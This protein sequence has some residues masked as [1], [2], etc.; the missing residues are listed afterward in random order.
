M[1]RNRMKTLASCLLLVGFWSSFASASSHET[2]SQAFG[3][4]THAVDVARRATE[5]ACDL[6]NNPPTYNCIGGWTTAGFRNYTQVPNTVWIANTTTID[7]SHNAI[8]FVLVNAFDGLTLMI[9]LYLQGN[10]ITSIPVGMLDTNIALEHLELTSNAITLI[11]VGMLDNNPALKDLKLN[12]NAITSIPVRMLDNAS[13]LTRLH[14]GENPLNCSN[15]SPD[16]G[17][18][19]DG[20]DGDDYGVPWIVGTAIS[21]I[22]TS[23]TAGTPETI[24]VDTVG[25]WQCFISESPT[26]SPTMSPTSP[27]VSPIVSPTVSPSADAAASSLKHNVPLIAGMV[28]L[29]VIIIGIV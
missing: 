4:S 24:T 20:D 25:F 12:N 27:T 11:L 2:G 15:F 22:C 3:N 26:V 19:G 16:I 10:A 21:S 17:D 9:A 8:T 14:L 28:V 7:L 18:G 1:A 23:C 6:D 5:I 29:C 13:A